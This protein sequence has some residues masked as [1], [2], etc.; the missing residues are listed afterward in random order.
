MAKPVHIKNQYRVVF[1]RKSSVDRE[2]T[3]YATAPEFAVIKK[4]SYGLKIQSV[5]LVKMNVGWRNLTG[6]TKMPIPEGV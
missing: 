4:F 1:D 5:A 6:Q 2:S 3:I